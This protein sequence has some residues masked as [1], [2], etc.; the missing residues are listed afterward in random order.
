MN[1]RIHHFK[2]RTILFGDGGTVNALISTGTG[3]GTGYASIAFNN[4]LSQVP[5]Y[6]EWTA[7]Y[8]YYKITYV[9]YYVTWISTNVD[10]IQT[11][12]TGVG[13]PILYYMIDRDDVNAIT[14]T[15]AGL[16]DMRA[17]TRCKRFCFSPSKRQCTF[18]FKPSLLS[19]NYSSTTSSGYTIMYDKWIDC[20][21][22]L[23]H[24][25]TKMMFHTPSP[26][27]NPS[28]ANYFEIEAAYYVSLKDPR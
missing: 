18:G 28:R 16:Q 4:L 17:N 26:S 19:E 20:N 2:R 3:V 27:G 10:A 5:Q 12:D 9:K 7:L 23:P 13:A 24:W 25:G 21:D 6:T 8:D 22:D 11:G 14:A 1:L 15:A